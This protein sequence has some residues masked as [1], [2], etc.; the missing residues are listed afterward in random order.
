VPGLEELAQEF[1]ECST[2]D[3]RL[4]AMEF[5][6]EALH[7]HSLLGKDRVDGRSSYTDLMGSMLSS[8]DPSE[9]D[10]D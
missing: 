9:P 2:Q 3:E 7:Q 1:V 4:S 5:V 10:L 8:I 6:L